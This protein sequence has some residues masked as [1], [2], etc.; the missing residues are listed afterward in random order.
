MGPTDSPYQFL[1]LFINVNFI[2][3]GERK[4]P[5]NPFQWSHAKINLPGDESYTPKITWVMKVR[6]DVHLA[7]E[8]FIYVD[9]GRIIAHSELVCWQVSKRFCST[10]NSLGIQDK[11]RKRT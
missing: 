3:Y 10:C 11:S 2:S 4:D 7:S 1:Q 9:G 8:V 5:L 6:S